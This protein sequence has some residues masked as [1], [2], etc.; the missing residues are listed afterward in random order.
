LS[1]I[2]PSIASGSAGAFAKSYAEVFLACVLPK[3]EKEDSMFAIA[4]YANRART[5]SPAA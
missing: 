4:Q 3:R 1:R 2:Q 5:T